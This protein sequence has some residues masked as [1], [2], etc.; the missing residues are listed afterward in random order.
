MC[1]NVYIFLLQSSG[2][3]M[4]PYAIQ[5][6]TWTI[7]FLFSLWFNYT[8]VQWIKWE[9]QQMGPAKTREAILYLLRG[10][11]TLETLHADLQPRSTDSSSMTREIIDN[12]GCSDWDTSVKRNI[13][14]WGF[15]CLATQ[16]DL[17]D[18]GSLPPWQGGPS[19]KLREGEGTW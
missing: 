5:F 14:S 18:L 6:W 3:R 4:L 10:P 12:L 16:R 19:F 11:R 17:G 1:I 15:L 8:H 9:T 13:R 7:V 2:D